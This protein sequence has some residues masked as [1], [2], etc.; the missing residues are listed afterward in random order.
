LS[1]TVIDDE[2]FAAHRTERAHGTVHATDQ[3]FLGTFKDLL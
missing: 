3:Y 1:A 2:R